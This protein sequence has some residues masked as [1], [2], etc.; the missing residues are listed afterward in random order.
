MI[1]IMPEVRELI[2]LYAKNNVDY[3]FILINDLL[4]NNKIENIGPAKDDESLGI[5]TCKDTEAGIYAVS[6]I[7]KTIETAKKY[8]PGISEKDLVKENKIIVY[9]IDAD[10]KFTISIYDKPDESKYQE[11]A[12][13]SASGQT[14]AIIYHLVL[15]NQS[16]IV[17][18]EWNVFGETDAKN[19]KSA[20][21]SMISDEFGFDIPD[22]D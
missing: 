4:F 11:I 20:I 16:G 7:H 9:N 12:K 22:F 19:K 21:K 3:R 5:F 10:N 17:D 8:C 14:T 18:S 6:S 2:A 15:A 13:L 1:L